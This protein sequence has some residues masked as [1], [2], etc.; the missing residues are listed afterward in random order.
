MKANNIF[1]NLLNLSKDPQTPILGAQAIEATITDHWMFEDLLEASP[2]LMDLANEGKEQLDSYFHL[3]EDIYLAL[4]KAVPNQVPLESMATT[5]Q[6]NW[7]LMDRLLTHPDYHRIHELSKLNYFAAGIGLQAMHENILAFLQANKDRLPPPPPPP[8]MVLQEVI[9]PSQLSQ[10]GPPGD[11]GIDGLTSVP[12]G[13]GGNVPSPGATSEEPQQSDSRDAGVP[14]GEA[15]DN[16]STEP[17]GQPN[18]SPT[19]QPESGPNQSPGGSQETRP[20][21]TQEELTRQK[22]LADFA[23]DMAGPV[24]KGV[25]EDIEDALNIMRG[26]GCTSGKM[27]HTPFETLRDA[28]ERI[29]ASQN[30]KDF[31][32]ILGRMRLLASQI[33]GGLGKPRPGKIDIGDDLPNALA[34]EKMLFL[35][36][37][38]RKD[39]V[40]RMTENEVFTHTVE[41]RGSGRGPIV[42]CVDLSSSMRG[43]QERW[44]KAT[45]L[46]LLEIA[47]KQGRSVVVIL[48]ES[49]IK[50]VVEFPHG[51]IDLAKL[52]QVAEC[53]ASGG[54]DFEIPLDEACKWLNRSRYKQGDVVFITDGECSVKP[55]FTRRFDKTKK[56]RQFK[57]HSVLIGNDSQVVRDFSDEVV[58]LKDF[59]DAE[60]VSMNIFKSMSKPNS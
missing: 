9:Q 24:T 6:V 34:S 40:R 48:F 52:L 33:G 58:H 35:N 1:A 28:L 25:T 12:D 50:D 26:W 31:S 49:H 14:S 53:G 38:T 60:R 36:P 27:R 7:H 47:H 30:L 11:E 43:D 45:A 5:H 23:K 44:A 15:Q 18:G 51:K 37:A 41:S 19:T 2:K 3:V 46:A 13:S 59:R 56:A 39:L 16:P 32:E 8:D 4:F 42:V 57:V 17:P 10:E 29:R 54:T 20:G 21:P 55:E 22:A